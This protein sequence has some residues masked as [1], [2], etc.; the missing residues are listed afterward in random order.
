MLLDHVGLRRLYT[1]AGLRICI[2]ELVIENDFIVTC[3]MLLI[4]FSAKLSLTNA[5]HQQGD[6]LGPLLFCLVLHEVVTAIAADSICL[7][8]SFHS[9]YMDDGVIAGP[10]QAALLALSIIKQLGPPLGLFI[11]TSKCELFSKGG[12]RGF[13]DAIK[14]SNALNCKILGAPIGDPIFVFVTS[15]L[16]R[17]EQMPLSFCHC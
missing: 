8:L 3:R 10:K 12:L 6:P 5:G 17:K 7:Q 11:N 15:S 13:P 16:W 1:V 2:E 4:L 9:S 14:K